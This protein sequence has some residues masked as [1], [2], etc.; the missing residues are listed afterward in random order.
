MERSP[1]EGA[2]VKHLNRREREKKL[3]EVPS[4]QNLKHLLLPSNSKITPGTETGSGKVRNFLLTDS[5]R[6]DPQPSALSLSWRSEPLKGL[7]QS[8]GRRVGHMMRCRAAEPEDERARELPPHVST[9][10]KTTRP[11]GVCL[12]VCLFEGRQEAAASAESAGGRG[13]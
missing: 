11:G 4:D 8:D 3:P 9:M 12:F 5:L 10:N 1:S 7:G 13:L 6:T 2:A